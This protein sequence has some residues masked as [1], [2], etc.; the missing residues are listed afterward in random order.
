[1]NNYTATK[2][3]A[4]PPMS[5]QFSSDRL[6]AKCNSWDDFSRALVSLT[7]KQKGDCF[8]RLT[9]LYLLTKPEYQTALKDV[10]ICSGGS[11]KLP[12]RIRTTLSHLPT[13]T[14]E[15]IDL[16]AETRNGEFWSIQCKYKTDI[17]KALTYKEL[18]TFT[19][20]TFNVC[21]GQ[22]AKAFV[23]H[24]S[25]KPVRK[26]K[27]LGNTTEIGLQRWL[28]MT[29][30]N[31]KG[32]HGLLKNKPVRPKRY[33]PRPHQ[34][35]AIN[36]AKK[37][38]FRDEQSRGKLIMPCGTGKSLTAYW[39]AQALDAKTILVV[40][41]SLA[42]IKQGVEDWTREI[43]AENETP[44]PEW[45]CV[46]S[47][48]SVGSIAKDDF[49]SEVYDLGLPVTTNPVEIQQFLKKRSRNRRI[50][51]VTYQSSPVFAK[52]A[53]KV[54]AKFDLA[55]LDEAHKT[56]GEKTK[57]FA[58]L[59]FDKNLPI[60]NRIFMTATERVMRGSHDE[61]VSMDN[62]D[63]YGDSFYQLSF[64]EAIH[65]EPA[66]ICDYKILTVFVTE[67]E[68][69]SVIEDKRFVKEHNRD[70]DTQDASE[71]AAA[72]ALR[73]DRKSVV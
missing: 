16:I 65:S 44:L 20:L 6:I 18:S 34:K 31:W 37:Y 50:V 22:F 4:V 67:G 39:I 17:E 27:L 33:S 15:G 51:F 72:I 19:N 49:V 32:I 61:V 60:K 12:K 47:D 66:I 63:V 26:R 21:A 14:D 45:L 52:V 68:I 23:A 38:F 43:A 69:K 64:K 56:A 40:V 62:K 53:R 13:N 8:E 54:N 25:S 71:L 35:K 36:A 55:I 30:E 57:A 41:P 9:Q 59:L 46:C 7:N 5:K 29:A 70:I 1:M 28:E 48:E 24:T 3:N 58:T 2:R 10:W 73:K 42:L 11:G